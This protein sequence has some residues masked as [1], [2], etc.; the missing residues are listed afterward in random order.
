L[1]TLTILRG[2]DGAP[3][4]HYFYFALAAFDLVTVASSLALTHNLMSIHEESVERSNEWAG[5][6]KAIGGMAAL[7]QEVNAPGNDVFDS[8]NPALEKL[9]PDSAS[10]R[11]NANLDTVKYDVTKGLTPAQQT[12]FYRSHVGIQQAM[13]EMRQETATIFKAYAAGDPAAASRRLA[14]MD[15]AYAVVNNRIGA[16]TSWAQG[17]QQAHLE[18]QMAAAR[19]LRGL[20]Y[21]RPSPLR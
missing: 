4:W 6:V 13:G 5:K 3:R 11:F 21:V 10:V 14:S 17:E 19:S 16:A 20:E 15:R 7:A 12:E 9:R 2:A 8:G 18:A 1:G